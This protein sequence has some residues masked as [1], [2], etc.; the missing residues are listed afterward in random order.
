MF[1]NKSLD[2]DLWIGKPVRGSVYDNNKKE[3]QTTL[4]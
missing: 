2:V 3:E 1:I 4:S